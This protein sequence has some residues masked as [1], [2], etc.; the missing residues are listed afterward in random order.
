[1]VLRDSLYGRWVS[2]AHWGRGVER[3]LFGRRRSTDAHLS[4]FTYGAGLSK[5]RQISFLSFFPVAMRYS[6]L[7]NN[8]KSLAY[9]RVGSRNFL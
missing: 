3:W 8:K 2:E 7:N 1:M 5:L 4:G 6:Q 9:R